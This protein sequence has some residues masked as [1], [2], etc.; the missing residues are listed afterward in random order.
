MFSI[1]LPF[2]NEEECI[3]EVVRSLVGHC[4]KE[5]LPIRFV[6]V[7]NGSHDKTGKIIRRLEEEF[8]EVQ[9]LTVKKNKGYGYGIRAGFKICDT[10]YLGFMCGDGQTDVNDVVKVVKAL[11]KNPQLDMCKVKRVK[12]Y[13]GRRRRMISFLY[14]RLFSL[15]FLFPLADVNAT[16]KIFKRSYFR[17]LNL[18]SNDWFIDAELMLKGRRQNMTFREIPTKFYSRKTGSSQVRSTTVFE[19]L[20]NMFKFRIKNFP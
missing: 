18:S 10:P 5:K 14:N 4:R 20:K 16:P 13:D 17:K 8:T 7:N 2:Y 6:L 19:F 12:R 15:L 3:E 11:Q 1:V 9:G